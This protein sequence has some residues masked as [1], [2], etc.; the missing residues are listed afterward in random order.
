MQKIMV[1]MKDVCKSFKEQSVLEDVNLKLENGKIYG[2]IGKNGC[3]KSVLLK[4]VAGLVVPT[5]GTV[6]VDGVLLKKGEYPKD[7][8]VILDCTGFLPEFTAYENL[9]SLA[10]IRGVIGDAEIAEALERVGLSS[11]AKKMYR[12]FSLGMKQKLAIAQAFME[13]PK[14]LLLDEPMNSLDEESV[15]SMRKMFREYV[16]ENNAVMLLTSHNMEDIDCLC[17]CVFEIKNKRVMSGIL[18]KEID[19]SDENIVEYIQD[20]VLDF[21]NILSLDKVLVKKA[22]HNV[23]KEE[24]VKALYVVSPECIE[25]FQSMYP[26]I[27]FINERQKRGS[28]SIQEALESNRKIVEIINSTLL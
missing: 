6:Y 14:L 16:E 12:K 9:R 13:K 10:E 27:N 17:D 20:L 3:G 2:F 1:E 22:L 24:L 21:E 7:M 28:I 15:Q 8:G 23:D 5:S 18:K 26:N 25:Y 4:M 19:K 11:D